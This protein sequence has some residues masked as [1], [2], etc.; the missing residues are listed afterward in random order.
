MTRRSE[1]K[2]N[3]A[4]TRR[5]WKTKH[6]T[7]SRSPRN[8]DANARRAEEAKCQL[9]REIVERLQ[10]E[11]ELRRLAT[12]D[13]LTGAL[14]RRRFFELGQLKLTHDRDVSQEIAVLMVD[15]DHFKL[16]NDRHGHP[17][18]DEALK[19]VVRRLRSALRQGDL[20]GR[21]GGEEFAIMLPAITKRPR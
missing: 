7:L 1:W 15:I 5:P 16:I 4:S 8:L 17:V 10:L 18:G 13:A 20:I 21:L 3:S 11:A 19:H 12:M 6:P 14:N 2:L 9:E